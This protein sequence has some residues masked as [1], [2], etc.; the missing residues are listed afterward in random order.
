MKVIRVF[1]VSW[2]SFLRSAVHS[3]SARAG[4]ATRT[5]SDG[6]LTAST[7]TLSTCFSERTNKIKRAVSQVLLQNRRRVVHGVDSFLD[8]IWKIGQIWLRCHGHRLNLSTTSAPH[9]SPTLRREPC[10]LVAR[11]DFGLWLLFPCSWGFTLPAALCVRRFLLLARSRLFALL[12]VS[13]SAE[14]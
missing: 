5:A 13:I 10:S 11:P 7:Q 4:P 3:R 8:T 12:R 1:C 2:L 6:Q 9:L 14:V